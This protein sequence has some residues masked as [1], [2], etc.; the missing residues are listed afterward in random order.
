M[1]LLDGSDL[2]NLL[3][4]MNITQHIELT[5]DLI[6]LISLWLVIEYSTMQLVVKKVVDH[7]LEHIQLRI[8]TNS[9]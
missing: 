3:F 7:I 2:W 9:N 8:L 1:Q 4:T 6:N 5:A